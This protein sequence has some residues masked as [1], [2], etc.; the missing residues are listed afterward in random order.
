MLGW[1]GLE[2]EREERKAE[3]FRMS[4]RQGLGFNLCVAPSGTS[5]PYFGV[6]KRTLEASGRQADE[7]EMNSGGLR[8]I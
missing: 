5:C 2:A 1:N 8:R 3:E 7:W 6:R 4:Y